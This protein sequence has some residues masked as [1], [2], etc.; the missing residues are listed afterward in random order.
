MLIEIKSEG[1]DEGESP[2]IESRKINNIAF[3]E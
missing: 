3:N 1:E 2:F